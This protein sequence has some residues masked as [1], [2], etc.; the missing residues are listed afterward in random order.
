MSL[1]Q[2]I[3]PILTEAITGEQ[4]LKMELQASEVAAISKEQ[5]FF[6]MGL[7]LEKLLNKRDVI[8]LHYLYG[9]R[10]SQTLINYQGKG[11]DPGITPNQKAYINSFGEIAV[12]EM[13]E[14]EEFTLDSN[15]SP[16]I[17]PAPYEGAEI[18]DRA[19]GHVLIPAEEFFVNALPDSFSKEL[20]TAT[21]LP[22]IEGEITSVA[23]NIAP[24]DVGEIGIAPN[25]SLSPLVS[26]YIRKSLDKLDAI[27]LR[28]FEIQKEISDLKK[29]KIISITFAERIEIRKRKNEL[30]AELERLQKKES[31]LQ[32]W[33]ESYA[34]ATTAI[35]KLSDPKTLSSI[36]CV[37]LYLDYIKN[38]IMLYNA[39]QALSLK[40]MAQLSK[41]CGSYS[42]RELKYFLK[43]AERK[44]AK[45][46]RKII[47]NHRLDG[48]YSQ[49]RW[50]K[51]TGWKKPAEVSQLKQF[52]KGR[53]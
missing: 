38:Q 10:N 15:G 6:K 33:L 9:R 34:E 47:R 1:I 29:Q 24:V 37:E 8:K 49:L 17:N 3:F 16:Q 39:M 30:N 43:V 26:D 41:T 53:R 45:I 40:V 46:N 12:T 42:G 52:F 44:L 48:Y 23:S 31:E 19:K 50:E 18:Q 2:T 25:T 13:E 51:W 14:R 11:F 21:C 36:P 7:S 32:I 27:A 35:E 22:K 28:K 4:N 5:D 20:I